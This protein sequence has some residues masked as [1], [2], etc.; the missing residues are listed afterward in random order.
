MTK[1]D[2]FKDDYINKSFIFIIERTY[3]TMFQALKAT[4]YLWDYAIR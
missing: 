1:Q 3:P 2:L 4:R